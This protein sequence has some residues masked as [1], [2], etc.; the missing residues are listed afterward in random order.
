M[1]RRQSTSFVVVV[2]VVVDLLLTAV[3][4]LPSTDT[5]HYAVREEISV[6][7]TI[8]DIVTDAGLHVYGL[9]VRDLVTT[10]R[11]AQRGDTI[12]DISNRRDID[13]LTHQFTR[14]RAAPMP[15]RF[16][17][18]RGSLPLGDSHRSPAPG[19][20]ES[21][22]RISGIHTLQKSTSR[23]LSHCLDIYECSGHFPTS[24]LLHFLLYSDALLRASPCMNFSAICYG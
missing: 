21:R 24:F 7:S 19:G 20:G 4:A 12:C 15:W 13:K 5:L 11:S 10:Q 22:E 1:R 6:G 18:P 9:E 14:L 3:R 2:V 8:A 23:C 16:V 17:L